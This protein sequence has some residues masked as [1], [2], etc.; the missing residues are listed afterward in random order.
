M[1]V[2]PDASRDGGR[3]DLEIAWVGVEDVADIL[4]NEHLHEAIITYE[5]VHGW[6][7][8]SLPVFADAE[9]IQYMLAGLVVGDEECE[10]RKGAEIMT[11]SR[12]L[13]QQTCWDFAIAGGVNHANGDCRVRSRDVQV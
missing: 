10:A 5:V 9:V 3:G 11:W 1:V 2:G 4:L 8:P 7:I 12:W 13:E 6:W